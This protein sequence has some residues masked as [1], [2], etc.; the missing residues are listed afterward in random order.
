VKVGQIKKVAVVGAGLMGHGIAQ[1]FAQEGFP[2]KVTDASESVLVEGKDKI[3]SNLTTFV[4][5]GFIN[6]SDMEQI[7]DRISVVK[8]LDQA[9]RDAEFVTEAVFEDLEVKRNL[10]KEM[11]MFCSRDT[12]LASNTSSFRMTDISSLMENPERALITHWFNPPHLVPLVECVLGERSREETYKT[13][14]ELLM[15]IKKVPVRVQKEI[16]GF[17]INRIQTAIHREV[18]SLLETGAASAEG[19][20]LAIKASLGFRLASIGP[21]LVRDLAGLGV[22][23]KVEEWLSEE[24]N[25]STEVNKILKDKV[26]RGE[27]G[28]KTGKGFF[29]YTPES[30]AVII[31]ERDRQFIHRLKHLYR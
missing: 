30:V 8:G 27:L 6:Q 15:K 3:R 4:E 11:E 13:T 10:F 23:Y 14:H 19:L 31:K 5:E 7:L 12:I 25:S 22:T 18:Y 29:E 21:L 17:L 9:V 24:I 2:V 26:A 1:A 16:P 28:V 20:D